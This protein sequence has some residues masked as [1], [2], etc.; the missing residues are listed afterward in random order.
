M[1]LIM[2]YTQNGSTVFT[3]KLY[4]NLLIEKSARIHCW[5]SPYC[6]HAVKRL[7]TALQG[8]IRPG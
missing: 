7:E 1:C 2:F 4:N 5:T 6:V 8:L 3:T